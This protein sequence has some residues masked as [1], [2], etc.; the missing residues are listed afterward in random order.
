MGDNYTE[1]DLPEFKKFLRREDCAL[2]CHG[3]QYFGL[4][5]KGECYCGHSVGKYGILPPDECACF[6]EDVGKDRNCVFEY[7]NG[8]NGVKREILE[9]APGLH[10]CDAAVLADAEKQ[11]NETRVREGVQ[12]SDELQDACLFDVCF[13]SS[14]YAGFSAATENLV[15]NLAVISNESMVASAP[16]SES[17]TAPTSAS[18]SA[19]SS[20]STTPAASCAEICRSTK[21][22]STTA[23]TTRT[24]TTRTT[25]F[26][27]MSTKGEIAEGSC[28]VWGDPHVQ[29]FDSGE[30]D[31]WSPKAREFDIVRGDAW[32]V[33]SRHLRMQAHY[34][35]DEARDE[36]KGT[37]RA[38]AV[39]GVL[40]G[41]H[42][43]RIEPMNGNVTWDGQP[44]LQDIPSRFEVLSGLVS[45]EYLDVGRRIDPGMFHRPLRVVDVRLF[46]DIRLTFNRWDSHV[47][48]HIT[49]RRQVGGQ[50][51]LCGN[52]NGDF[53][54]DT[55]E[56]IMARGAEVSAEE[57]LF[58][59]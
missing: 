12:V 31:A 43:L 40:L 15:D 47:D 24:T 3:F 54:D 9:T 37:A 20:A 2:A 53:A 59:A 11:C 58:E 38:F 7:S 41:A 55:T 42:M 4:Q 35:P 5:A 52:F 14:A 8:N 56:L 50:D 57:S 1:H 26:T 51:G 13:G 33:E 36:Q 34:M 21:L 39:T 25:T 19:Q 22:T 29:V 49:M 18:T 44:I 32:I 28:L 46:P 23:T 6:N 48:A 10:M 17:S 45:A 27:T 16:A 30:D